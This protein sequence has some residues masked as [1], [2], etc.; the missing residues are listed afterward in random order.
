LLRFTIARF[1]LA[2]AA[3]VAAATSATVATSAFAWFAGLLVALNSFA[4]RRV[5]ARFIA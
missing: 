3:V 5:Y 1:V 4:L 2:W